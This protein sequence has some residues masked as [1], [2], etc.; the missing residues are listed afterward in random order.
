MRQ[1]KSLKD[2]KEAEF[3]AEKDDKIKFTPLEEEFE[4]NP[5]V[6]LGN[7]RVEEEAGW[8]PLEGEEHGLESAAYL[9]R[10]AMEEAMR[11]QTRLQGC[12]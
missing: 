6:D 2:M 9:E 12:V 3:C 5:G 8:T 11:N 4:A 1:A 7:W 10:Q